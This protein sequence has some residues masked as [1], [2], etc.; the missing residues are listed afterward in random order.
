MA[1]LA[2]ARDAPQL[3]PP[4]AI[5]RAQSFPEAFEAMREAEREAAL[6]S[7]ALNPFAP[8]RQ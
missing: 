7:A 1:M 2:T 3:A 4:P 5:A 8:A 6:A